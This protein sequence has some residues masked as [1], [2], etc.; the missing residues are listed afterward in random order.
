MMKEKLPLLALAPRATACSF[1]WSSFQHPV[2]VYLQHS[3]GP[4]SG[5]RERETEGERERGR[6]GQG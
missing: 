3:S 2:P 6:A 5:Y 4:S 1:V